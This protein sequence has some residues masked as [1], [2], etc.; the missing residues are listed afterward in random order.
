MTDVGGAKRLLKLIGAR[1][2][3]A[4][5]GKAVETAALLFD[6]PLPSPDDVLHDFD[7]ALNKMEPYRD[8]PIEDA[9]EHRDA[10]S[11][12]HVLIESAIDKLKGTQPTVTRSELSALEA[13]VRA[14][15]SR[16]SVLLLR[17]NLPD[18]KHPC[19]LA[20]EE[21]LISA[22]S[23]LEAASKA[24]GRIQPVGGSSEHYFGSG[25]L[26]SGAGDVVTNR[27][28]AIAALTSEEITVDEQPQWRDGI[29][30]YVVLG[31]WRSSSREGSILIAAS[32]G[33][34]GRSSCRP[35]KAM[36]SRT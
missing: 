21:R 29:S 3:C 13:V 4:A 35:R 27:H 8:R 26:C 36:R 28:V 1:R 24:T 32:A 17:N 10:R 22:S 12:V 11:V 9:R 7:T 16:P 15:G 6:S 14:D 23:R 20:W 2:R 34:Y 31:G 30:R 18:L 33:G 25:Y 19:A 5:Q